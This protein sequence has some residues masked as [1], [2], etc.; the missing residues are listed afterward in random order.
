MFFTPAM[1]E[2]GSVFSAQLGY[3]SAKAGD[4]APS[5]SAASSRKPFQNM[6][7]YKYIHMRRPVFIGV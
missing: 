1:V 7:K 4:I 5:T 6:V 3:Y 2:L